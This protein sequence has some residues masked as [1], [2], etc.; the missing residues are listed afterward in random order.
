[1]ACTSSYNMPK[2][3]RTRTY[4]ADLD[5]VFDAA[6]EA[7]SAAKFALIEADREDNKITARKGT[8]MTS[9]RGFSLRVVL[10]EKEDGVISV[11]ANVEEAGGQA[12]DW[13]S[14]KKY[15]RR[16]LDALDAEVATTQ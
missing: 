5:T 13:G 9:W 2:E 15:V 8:T 14:S 1:M 11:S 6:V 4:T 12:A 3:E 16:Y 10:F 7:V